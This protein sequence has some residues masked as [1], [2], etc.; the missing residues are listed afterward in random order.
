MID[1]TIENVFEN[2]KKLIGREF[3]YDNVYEAFGDYE[4]DGVSEVIADKSS[5][6]GYDYIA[7]INTTGSVQFVFETDSDDVIT[8]VRMY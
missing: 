1:M 6:Q 5:N 8:D 4:E 2:L 7:Y 3:D